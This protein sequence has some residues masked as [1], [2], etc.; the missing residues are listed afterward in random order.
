MNDHTPR[1]GHVNGS[2]DPARACSHPH[3]EAASNGFGFCLTCGASLPPEIVAQVSE[4]HQH[5]EAPPK[6]SKPQ[7]PEPWPDP[8]ATG[9]ILERLARLA[10]R[11]VWLPPGA[12][13][14][15]GAWT[16]WTWASEHTV[17]LPMLT[18]TSPVKQCGK[19]TLLDLLL[20]TMARPLSAASASAAA[21]FRTV[22]ALRPTL[23][24]DECDRW[25]RADQGEE[26]IGILNAGHKRGGA[27]LRCVAV[28]DDHETRSFRCDSPKALAGIGDLPDTLADRSIIVALERR[29]SGSGATGI[30]TPTRRA[31]AALADADP[32]MGALDNRPADNWRSLY[33]IADLAGQNPA[34]GGGGD[35]AGGRASIQRAVPRDV[36]ARLSRCIRG[37]RLAGEDDGGR[38]RRG[39]A[40]ARGAGNRSRHRRAA[41]CCRGSASEPGRCIRSE[42]TVTRRSTSPAPGANTCRRR[43]APKRAP[44]PILP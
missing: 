9:E 7:A 37:G 17:I 41:E 16:L 43:K 28:G 15:I 10:A 22:E 5:A 26:R 24:L 33:A 14:T 12:A 13:T 8:V 30:P 38:S 4:Q 1:N 21:L 36:A 27:V 29:S 44:H 25:L 20:T 19:T 42:R 18:I 6:P 39:T 32:D 11:F 35:G 40:R 3:I 2:A 23:L 31:C 34:S